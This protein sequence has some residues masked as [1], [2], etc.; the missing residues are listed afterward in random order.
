MATPS[1]KPSY[2]TPWGTTV[3]TGPIAPQSRR[4]G[5]TSRCIAD[6]TARSAGQHGTSPASKPGQQILRHE[7]EPASSFRPVAEL[8]H[9]WQI[10]AISATSCVAARSTCVRNIPATLGRFRRPGNRRGRPADT[11]RAIDRNHGRLKML[12]R[13]RDSARPPCRFPQQRYLV[14][15][16]AWKAG[17]SLAS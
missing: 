9:H 12:L 2:T 11:E 16:K 4:H 1:G 13:D 8:P 15:L 10:L 6:I 17:R 14:L 3:D 7:G 5:A